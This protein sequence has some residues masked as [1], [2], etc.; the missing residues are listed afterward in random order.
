MS[1]EADHYAAGAGKSTLLDALSMRSRGIRT[2][3]VLLNGE[4]AT[5][6]TII[7]GCT[8]ISQ[9]SSAGETLVK[10]QPVK[11]SLLCSISQTGV[12]QEDHFL[13]SMTCFETLRM[14][15]AMKMKGSSKCREGIIEESLCAVGLLRV[16]DSQV[17]TPPCPAEVL[18][19]SEWVSE[20]V[21]RLQGRWPA[22][23]WSQGQGNLRRGEET[24]EH[25]LWHC[26]STGAD[27]HRRADVR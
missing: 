10:L 24:F 25:R 8:Y 14:A 11:T 22:S 15:A 7:A 20:P 17:C 6:A 9:V 26:R 4:A 13:P 2:G 5:D 21:S 19:T 18:R 27:F 23:R 12:T 16:A 3:D 1:R